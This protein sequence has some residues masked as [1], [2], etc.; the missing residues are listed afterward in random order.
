M[1]LRNRCSHRGYP[2]SAGTRVGDGIECG[3]H[4]FTFDGT[5][6][7]VA[8]P[9]QSRVPSRADVTA[10]PT[11]EVGPFVW[12]WVGE[13]VPEAVPDPG[14][15]AT[16]HLGEQGW[17]FSTGYV[18][19]AAAYGLIIDNLLDLSHESWVHSTKIGTPEIAQTPTTTETDLEHRVVR[20]SRHMEGVT[21]PPTYAAMG[22]E[23]PVDRWQDIEFHAPS[24]YVLHVR[25]AKAGTPVGSSEDADSYRSRV[26]YGVTP[27]DG[28]STHYFFAIGRNRDLGDPSV[29]AATCKRQYDLIAEDAAAVEAVQ[30]MNDAEGMASE[31][32][33]KVDTGALAAR[34]LLHAL[35]PGGNG[36]RGGGGR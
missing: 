7:C 13:P 27:C 3:Y 28:A 12:A 33:V 29:T 17:E 21:S 10:Y 19:I 16:G 8:V 36:P 15:P 30:A 26:V 14:P 5:G 34:R 25:V 20:M 23:S 2:L 32:S 24:L 1:A 4:G 11:V 6:R 18:S 31:V 35:A 22:L 9:G